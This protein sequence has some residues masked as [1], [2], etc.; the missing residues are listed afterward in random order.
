VAPWLPTAAR[1][2]RRIGARRT[3][4]RIAMIEREDILPNPFAQLPAPPAEPDARLAAI[5]TAIELELQ[6]F[7]DRPP[8][9]L[10]QHRDNN[11]FG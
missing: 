11:Q 1:I 3:S 6:A 4:M 10:R 7:L 8:L 5:I 2:A 9:F